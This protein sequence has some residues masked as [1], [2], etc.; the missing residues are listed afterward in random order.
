MW[1]FNVHMWCE[2]ITTIKVINTS[3]S[4]PIVFLWGGEGVKH[5]RSTLLENCKLWTIATIYLVKH[6]KS[7]VGIRNLLRILVCQRTGGSDL[8]FPECS[9]SSTPLFPM[10]SSRVTL[11]T[12]HNCE[13]SSGDG[14]GGQS[15]QIYLIPG[16]TRPLF[17][18]TLEERGGFVK[19]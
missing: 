10:R 8:S 6:S 14:G 9:F 11:Q 19:K 17:S 1:W 18:L 3:V 5:L 15:F 12:H 16:W 4:L 2:M 7:C 13:M